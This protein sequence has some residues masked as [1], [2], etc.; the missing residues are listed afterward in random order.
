M[1][2]R[3]SGNPSSF[4]QEVSVHCHRPSYPWNMLLNQLPWLLDQGNI[5]SKAAWDDGVIPREKAILQPRKAEWTVLANSKLE[6]G[7]WW[8][9]QAWQAV[10]QAPLS[11]PG[12]MHSWR[13]PCMHSIP[14]NYDP[15]E[16]VAGTQSSSCCAPFS[17][18]HIMTIPLHHRAEITSVL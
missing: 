4:H 16:Q 8:S 3:K 17:F 14:T 10:D 7:I 18:R 2:Q 11:S 1:R 13:R 12:L 9:C 15:A 5:Y 6:A